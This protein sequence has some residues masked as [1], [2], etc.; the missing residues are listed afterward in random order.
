MTQEEIFAKIGEDEQPLV[1]DCSDEAM[2]HIASVL[3]N[4]D[5]MVE[6]T[7]DTDKGCG[8][9]RKYPAVA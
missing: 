8:R 1:C 6:C 3:G 5:I 2:N 4:G 7:I 9:F